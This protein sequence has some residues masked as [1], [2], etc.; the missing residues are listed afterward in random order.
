MSSKRARWLEYWIVTLIVLVLMTSCVLPDAGDDCFSDGSRACKAGFHCEDS[1]IGKRSFC[2]PDPPT[3]VIPPEDVGDSGE[4]TACVAP[5]SCGGVEG[6]EPN[7][8]NTC[9]SDTEYVSCELDRDG[10][11]FKTTTQAVTCPS[12]LPSCIDGECHCQSSCDTN[13]KTECV[14]L[15]TL[16]TCRDTNGDGCLEW[17]TDP[18][19]A[20]KRCTADSPCT[21][22]CSNAC[23][24]DARKCSDESPPRRMTCVHD[25]LNQPCNYF[26]T[27]SEDACDPGLV[28]ANEQYCC[29]DPC[30]PN[31]KQCM[32]GDMQ[33]FQTCSIG[34]DGCPQW[35]ANGTSCGDTASCTGAGECAV[36]CDADSTG[37]SADLTHSWTCQ[38]AVKVLIDCGGA[39]CSAGKCNCPNTPVCAVTGKGECVDGMPSQRHICQPSGTDGQACVHWNPQADCV[40]PDVCDP[41]TGQ[42]S[43]PCVNRPDYCTLLNSMKCLDTGTYVTCESNGDC[44]AWS[45]SSRLC[46]TGQ[47][48]S[49]ASGAAV[50]Q[51]QKCSPVGALS[52]GADSQGKSVIQTCDKNGKWQ[53]QFQCQDFGAAIGYPAMCDDSTHQCVST[54]TCSPDESGNVE[55]AS[56]GNGY[57]AEFSLYCDGAH[58][59]L[60][61]CPAGEVCRAPYVTQQ[62][63]DDSDCSWDA[64]KCEQCFD[65]LWCA[66]QYTN[67][68]TCSRPTRV[69]ICPSGCNS[70][71]TDC[72]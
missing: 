62:C 52:C 23:T 32:R 6:C 27:T 29:K 8:P 70:S 20:E 55:C 66:V 61:L 41:A 71:H 19:T 7:S 13:G 34:K 5:T 11:C 64:Q 25:V 33:F 9:V 51:V 58:Y 69:K 31:S 37:C 43:T 72:S 26:F 63:Y 24:L 28:C 36:G 3:D 14:D 56:Y 2:V 59:R 1:T 40:S 50:C 16:R 49:G 45:T 4:D 12:N 68:S 15:T 44:Q 67:G 39:N 42:C 22:D 53:V 10:C 60:E 65:T 30:I 21:A 54:S 57:I 38:K 17:A 47:V 18:C 48:C 35:N 46:P